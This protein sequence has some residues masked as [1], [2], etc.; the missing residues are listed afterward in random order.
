MKKFIT[1]IK[2]IFDSNSYKWLKHIG[3]QHTATFNDGEKDYYI[4]FDEFMPNSYNLYFYY[5]NDE[6]ER[7]FELTKNRGGKEFKIFGNVK[8]CV[9]N[10]IEN[11]PHILFMGFSS[12]SQER[13]DLYF[14]FLQNLAMLGFNYYVKKIDDVEYYFLISEEIPKLLRGNYINNFVKKDKINK[15]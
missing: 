4:N 12:Y 5:F 2:E 6:N 14:M 10:F 3:F 15:K 7:V 9:N 8:N 13:R 1:Y 11:H